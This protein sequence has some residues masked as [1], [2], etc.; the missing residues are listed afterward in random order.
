MK[1]KK[2]K[3]TKYVH[4]HNANPNNKRT[5]DCVIRALSVAMDKT[6]D[7]VLAMVPVLLGVT[8]VIYL[9]MSMA[10]GDPAKVILG[11]QATPEQIADNMRPMEAMTEEEMAV[12]FQAATIIKNATAVDCTGC[13]Y[14]LKHCPMEVPIPK[15]FGLYNT[16]Q[17]YPRHLW[18]VK[19]AYNALDITASGCVA[20]GSCT[21]HC[22]QKLAI[23]EYMEQIRKVFE[24]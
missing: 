12:M 13:G 1:T 22:P 21:D 20:C 4:F 18:K 15:L 2:Y 16:Y 10:P 23:P 14:C 7:D 8:L 11:E 6:W 9:I 3:D 5:G 19:P 17:T 24:K